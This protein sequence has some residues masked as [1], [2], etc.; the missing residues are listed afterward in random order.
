MKYRK[1]DADGDY[2]FGVQAEFL[3]DTPLTVAQAIYTRLLL[4]TNEWFLDST[5]GTPYAEQIEGFGTQSTRDPAIQSRILGTPGVEELLSYSSALSTDRRFTVNAR[6][7]TIYGQVQAVFAMPTPAAPSPPVPPPPPPSSPTIAFLTGFEGSSGSSDWPYNFQFP[8]KLGEGFVTWGGEE[9]GP[10]GAPIYGERGLQFGSDA[11]D[12][13]EFYEPAHPVV[14]AFTL[15]FSILI[16]DGALPTTRDLA[17]LF[18]FAGSPMFRVWVTNNED[19]TFRLDAFYYPNFSGAVNLG[20]FAFDVKHDFCLSV[21]PEE[22]E[23]PRRL[24]VFEAGVR[25]FDDGAGG[26]SGGCNYMQLLNPEEV[27]SVG[28]MMTFDEI[29]LSNIVEHQTDYVVD[30]PFVWEDPAPEGDFGFFEPRGGNDPTTA[31]VANNGSV[32]G[33]FSL[34]DVFL[35]M[36]LTPFVDPPDQDLADGVTYKIFWEPVE[37][38]APGPTL[39]GEVFGNYGT[40]ELNPTIVDNLMPQGIATIRC[41]VGG[42]PRNGALLV[43]YY[44][45]GGYGGMSWEHS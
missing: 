2:Q 18:N 11:N 23:G 6:V 42:V 30:L 25:L 20:P 8:M 27:P 1:L 37:P 40:Q 29:K 7:L 44:P 12:F 17:R 41:Y 35:H 15:Q 4:H 39:A 26:S 31:D 28:A 34:G 5:E 43:T 19:G 10:F 45:G 32:E 24:K 14:D 16:P 13:A 21:G 9:P 38:G 33:T 22:D 3:K 36:G